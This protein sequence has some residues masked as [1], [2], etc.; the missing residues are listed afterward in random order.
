MHTPFHFSELPR[1]VSEYRGYRKTFTHRSPTDKKGCFS[2]GVFGNFLEILD[3]VD[4]V[5]LEVNEYQPRVHGCNFY[6][7]SQVTA[8]VE[9]HHPLFDL[10]PE[11][12]TDIDRQIAEN[13]VE[14][15][16]DGATI[17][18]GIGA[19]PNAI[20]E[21][22]IE[23]DRHHLGCHTEMLPDAIMKMFEAGALDNTRKTFHP[24]QFNAFF[25]AGSTELYRWSDDNPMILFTPITYNN[26]PYNVA[27]NDKMVTINSTLEIDI[28]GQCCSDSFGPYQYTATGGQV[29]FTR[30]AWMSRGGKAFIAL[31]STATD[32]DTGET[33]SKIVPQLRPGAA[34]T[35][36]RTDVIYVATEYGVVNLKGKGLRER[37]RAL[38]G[39]A[40]P[41]F[42][43]ELKRYARYVK[44]FVLTEHVENL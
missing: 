16:E 31:R 14:Y 43:G 4:E 32:R 20:G 10:P 7:M 18:L 40:H 21:C 35:L 11:I 3:K 22:L 39:I 13:I 17:R 15:I 33:V 30:G 25:A 19:V 9:N 5:I 1:L 8:V 26:N 6:H 38:I 28:T 44:Y 27:K 23:H 34:V 42:R 36:T 2:G 41:D 29:D 37:A 24:H 12:P